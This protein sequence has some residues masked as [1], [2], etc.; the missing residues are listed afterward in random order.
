MPFLIRNDFF[1]S[2][3]D[4]DL[5]IFTDTDDNVLNDA[6][7]TSTIML[8]SYISDRYDVSIM[9]PDVLL[10]DLV[11]TFQIGNNVVL[12]ASDFV[13]GHAYVVGDLVKDPATQNVYR[14]ILNGTSQPLSNATYWTLY[15]V[16]KQIYTCTAI[17][18]GQRPNNA[19]YFSEGDARNPL[20]IRL[21]VDLVL[22]DI[23][24][25]LSPRNIP[26]HRIQR[27][28]DAVKYLKDVA[29]P[30]SNINPNFPLVDH[31]TDRGVDISFGTTTNLNAY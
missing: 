25:I 22:Y 28:D 29:N 5:D 12:L 8:K 7:E 9:F 13:S 18:T 31:G 14:S 21:L 6:I 26:E 11:N 2:I 17:A 1:T 19:S 10:Y 30:R 15:G 20:L 27:R 4:S 16:N 24:S 23:H 3:E